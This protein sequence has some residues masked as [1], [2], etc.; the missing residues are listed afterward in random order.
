MSDQTTY[1]A[2]QPFENA[3]RGKSRVLQPIVVQSGPEAIRKAERIA[4]EKGGAIAF[5]RTG[6]LSWGEFDDPVILGTFGDVPR[7]F[8]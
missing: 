4:K 8:E 1:Y 6:D 7:E 3:P 2:V 5:S